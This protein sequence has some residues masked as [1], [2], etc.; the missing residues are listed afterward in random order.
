MKLHLVQTT[1]KDDG[2]A[3]TRAPAEPP[4][5]PF[6]LPDDVDMLW[7]EIVPELTAARLISKVDGMTVELAL[8]HF[9][10]AREASTHLILDGAVVEDTA[11]GGTKKSPEAQIFKDN[12]TAF[13]EYAK[14]LGLSFAS[15]VRVTMPKGADDGENPFGLT[16]T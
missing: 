9:V 13:L 1:G 4:D 12:S 5:K 16:G 6:G 3:N 14:Q 7:D 10:M 15:R 8:R 11:H 2:T